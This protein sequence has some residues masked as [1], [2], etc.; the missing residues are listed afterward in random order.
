MPAK[1]VKVAS[2]SELSPGEMKLVEIEDERILLANVEGSYYAV[3]EVCTHAEC[4]LSEGYLDGE[5]VECSCHGSQFNVKTGAVEG[6][7]AFEDLPVY[8]VQ[9]EGEDILIGP[10]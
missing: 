6:P 1:F 8:P 3:S 2:T 4:P 9:V 10:A 5:M 7:P